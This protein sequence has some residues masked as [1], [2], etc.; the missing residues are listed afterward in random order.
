LSREDGNRSEAERSKQAFDWNRRY[1]GMG[2]H[3]WTDEADV[4]AAADWEKE[5]EAGRAKAAEFLRVAAIVEDF[6]KR[7]LSE[8]EWTARRD[9]HL[10]AAKKARAERDRDFQRKMAEMGAMMRG[11]G[12]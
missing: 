4:L 9:E 11:A 12:S 7:G 5:L 6:A 2:G 3:Y 10:A 1:N 8:E